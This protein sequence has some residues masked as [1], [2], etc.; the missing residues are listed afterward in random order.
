MT[1]FAIA[2]V[3]AAAFSSAAGAQPAPVTVSPPVAVLPRVPEAF[4]GP[5]IPFHKSGGV[6]VGT[7]GLYPFD[8]G[9]WLLGGTE[10]LSRYAGSFT[11]VGP[12]N[13]VYGEPPTLAGPSA[14]R[15]HLLGRHGRFCR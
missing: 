7:R 5:A 10:G 3:L 12:G 1:R 8:T 11:M 6:V 13:P 4:A 2:A 15:G 14:G 9:D